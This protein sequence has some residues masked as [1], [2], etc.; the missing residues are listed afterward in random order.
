MTMIRS[1]LSVGGAVI[2]CLGTSAAHA[3][4]QL[5][6]TPTD[7]ASTLQAALIPS[8]SLPT[9]IS[10]ESFTTIPTAANIDDDE[11]LGTFTD[12]SFTSPS[13]SL[14]NGIVLSTGD[15][16][17]P[18]GSAITSNKELAF[19]GA[20]PIPQTQTDACG[21]NEDDQADSP[22]PG[23]EYGTDQTTSDPAGVEVTFDVDAAAVGTFVRVSIVLGS[24][25][26][27][28][29][30][31]ERPTAPEGDPPQGTVNNETVDC[32]NDTFAAYLD[33]DNIALLNGNLIN[34]AEGIIVFNNNVSEEAEFADLDGDFQ[35]DEIHNLIS[36]CGQ[37][38]DDQAY[39]N[40]DWGIEYDGVTDVITFE[41]SFIT[42][43]NHTLK[44]IVSDIG[45]FDDN[46]DPDEPD[47][48]LDTAVFV[49]ALEFCTPPT[50]DEWTLENGATLSGMLASSPSH[51]Y[52]IDPLSQA[53]PSGPDPLPPH[54]RR[55]KQ[56]E[57]AFSE[58]VLNQNGT[59]LSASA[60]SLSCTDTQTFDP[61]L[62]NPCPSVSSIDPSANPTVVVFFDGPI[63]L[64]EWTTL[65]MAVESACGAEADLDIDIASLPCDVNQDGNV[66]LG[67]MSEWVIKFNGGSGGPSYLVDSNRDNQLG[68]ADSSDL[69]NNFNGNASIG[70]YQWNGRFLPARP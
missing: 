38:L 69:V 27:P 54:T 21:H 4:P 36:L 64:G 2:L 51:D 52:L 41:G 62:S 31:G 20:H 26:F 7:S 25:E 30:A 35:D 67:D 3:Q 48:I 15:L 47:H 57:V 59:A 46:P 18:N 32:Y 19:C 16:K 49:Q 22:E 58:T 45:I 33:E 55:I 29:W 53:E 23:E 37:D 63:P 39:D 10:V 56:I 70:Y 34:A 8:A 60:F 61:P 5:S 28:E 14:G 17:R 44:L 6:I 24:D 40:V 43:G 65:T 13:L 12:F 9:G 1:F 66:G 11:T 42:P 68:L 50:V